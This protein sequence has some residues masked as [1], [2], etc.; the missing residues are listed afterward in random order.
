MYPAN[1][2]TA[3]PR[4][5]F[6]PRSFEWN[7]A[8][9][10]PTGLLHPRWAIRKRFPIAMAFR[11]TR[12]E[13]SAWPPSISARRALVCALRDR[14]RNLNDKQAR[15]G[16]RR[17][18]LG[19]A[20]GLG[21]N[22]RRGAP[23]AIVFALSSE[24]AGFNAG[25]GGRVAR[26]PFAACQGRLPSIFPGRRRMLLD[27]NIGFVASRGGASAVRP[28]RCWE[29]A[30]S[31]PS[32]L[33]GEAKLRIRPQST[34]TRS[35]AT[36]GMD[37]EARHIFIISPKR[38]H[39]EALDFLRPARNISL[40]TGSTRNLKWPSRDRLGV[41]HS[42]TCRGRRHRDPFASAPVLVWTAPLFSR[43]APFPSSAS[44]P[45]DTTS[46]CIQRPPWEAEAS[47]TMRSQAE[48]GNESGPK[49][50]KSGSVQISGLFK[51]AGLMR[52]QTTNSKGVIRSREF[53]PNGERP[54]TISGVVVGQVAHVLLEFRGMPRYGIT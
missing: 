24:G 52:G 12:A 44:H 48:L 6:A 32:A 2:P 16:S 4:L 11:K 30:A 49:K 18:L 10:F 37:S 15:R 51:E 17:V 5:S 1:R 40:S 53:A 26:W 47:R 41:V 54:S 28:A 46:L 21:R 9:R 45:R 43:P 8:R 35:F 36:S 29:K 25:P 27:F 19:R 33:A 23:L 38:P 13:H 3:A 7:F 39:W 14:C 34:R 50:K 20:L 42:L 22:R 31:S